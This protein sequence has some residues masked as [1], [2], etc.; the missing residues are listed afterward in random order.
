MVY[1]KINSKWVED[2]NARPV[3]IKFLEEDIGKTLLNMYLGNT[4]WV[5]LLRQKKEKKNKQ[6]EPNWT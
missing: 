3:I 2:L 1:T 5:S 6:I 4:F